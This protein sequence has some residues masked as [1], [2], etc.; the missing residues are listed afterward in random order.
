MVPNPFA[1]RYAFDLGRAENE[2][3]WEVVNAV[4]GGV[5][6]TASVAVLDTVG[7]ALEAVAAGWLPT[8]RRDLDEVRGD[9]RDHLSM[10][11]DWRQVYADAL[12]VF[13]VEHHPGWSPA[14]RVLA[15]L[16][17]F[18]AKY[19][20]D[21]ERL[22]QVALLRAGDAVK[23]ARS[24][25]LVLDQGVRPPVMLA[26]TEVAAELGYA[27]P[28]R[29]PRLPT[30]RDFIREV[31][32]PDHA[33]WRKRRT[34][35]T[36][37]PGSG[38]TFDEPEP[39]ATVLA[40]HPR[41]SGELP[42]TASWSGTVRV[43]W[44]KVGLDDYR[45]LPDDLE[46]LPDAAP[47]SRVAR[48]GHVVELAHEA[49]NEMR[50]APRTGSR[51]VPPRPDELP[52]MVEREW[53]AKLTGCTRKE[54]LALLQFEVAAAGLASSPGGGT[55][56]RRPTDRA[57]YDWIKATGGEGEAWTLPAEFETW[58]RYLRS[59]R[60]KVGAQK[61]NPRRDRG[62]RSIVR[63]AGDGTADTGGNDS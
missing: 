63:P 2:F 15:H 60:K 17:S 27:A 55:G 45:R 20:D 21:L 51:T 44:E 43:L 22:V 62:G 5:T 58:S 37:R 26:D 48:V 31:P 12:D 4:V 52:G 36:K 33:A 6:G 24:L 14:D 7:D 32:N 59:A 10:E 54:K 39:P 42:P 46:T 47:S 19:R 56:D 30:L 8:I 11:G 53:G 29:P 3:R 18:V 28:G 41:K 61:N 35:W 49:F 50:S 25:G 1:R 9:W 16:W 23:A 38:R 57:A 13:T 34:G 40:P